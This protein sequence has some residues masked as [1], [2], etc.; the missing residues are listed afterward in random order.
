MKLLDLFLLLLLLVW[1]LVPRVLTP[2]WFLQLIPVAVVVE[3]FLVWIDVSV[4]D[5]GW[6]DSDDCV[7]KYLLLSVLLLL[8]FDSFV[9]DRMGV[10][11]LRLRALWT[12]LPMLHRLPSPSVICW[13]FEYS[14]GWLL[15]VLDGAPVLLRLDRWS[16]VRSFAGSPPLLVVSFELLTKFMIGLVTETFERGPL[17][18][19][20]VTICFCWS[21]WCRS[22]KMG[23]F[24]S[25]LCDRFVPTSVCQ[26]RK[27]EKG[28]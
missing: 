14:L 11:K 17:V 15:A 2:G 12:A 28:V 4:M 16:T 26:K 23:P 13:L 6:D 19:R 20:L 25:R 18:A 21:C 5:V 8:L 9:V 7:R 22:F 10:D 27:K 3:S 24:D 1:L